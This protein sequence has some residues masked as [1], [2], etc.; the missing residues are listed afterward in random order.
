MAE[1]YLSRNALSV[2]SVLS[3]QDTDNSGASQTSPKV[4]L[5]SLNLP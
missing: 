5:E 2:S 3:Q 4:P 1:Q